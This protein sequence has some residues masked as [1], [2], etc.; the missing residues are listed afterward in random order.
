MDF[1]QARE[2]RV[3]LFDQKVLAHRFYWSERDPLGA[4]TACE[5]EAVLDLAREAASRLQAR[6]LAV[7]IAELEDGSWRVIEVGD[8][9]H[10]GL[11]H[12]QPHSY[13]QALQAA[14]A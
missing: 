7:D 11:A 5:L 4:L 9:Q 6:A 3:M 1:P 12:I 2:Y 8:A 14:T 10:T 13:W